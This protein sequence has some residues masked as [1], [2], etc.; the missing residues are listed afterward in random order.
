MPRGLDTF[1]FLNSG[2]EAVE[3]AVK[4]ARQATGKPN[5]IVFK[6]TFAFDS[7]LFSPGKI[8]SI[9]TSA[10]V[11]PSLTPL[12]NTQDKRML[13]SIAQLVRAPITAAPWARW[14]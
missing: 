11:L 1:V 13:F 14:P 8:I 4:L 2:S 3:N 9:N 12:H 7:L 10:I 6:V 5:V